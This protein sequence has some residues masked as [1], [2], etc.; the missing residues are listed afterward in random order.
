MIFKINLLLFSIK[1]PAVRAFLLTNLAVKDGK[2]YW[3]PN[4]KALLEHFGEIGSFPAELLER[5]FSK[6]TL[7]IRGQKS[8]YIPLSDFANIQKTFTNAQLATVENAGHW[9]HAENTVRFMEIMLP[10]LS[11]HVV[12]D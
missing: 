10:F 7:F 2:I 3:K 9:P 11:G 5:N 1:D 6:P 12:A 8:L 4:L